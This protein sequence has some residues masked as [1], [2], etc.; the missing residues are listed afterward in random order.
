MYFNIFLYA[1]NVKVSIL[2][3]PQVTYA[4]MSCTTCTCWYTIQNL[5]RRNWCV[6]KSSS[7]VIANFL[8]WG[9]QTTSG[10]LTL[11]SIF[12]S[13]CAQWMYMKVHRVSA[14]CLVTLGSDTTKT[15][16]KGPRPPPPARNRD[17]KQEKRPEKAG[18]WVAKKSSTPH[19]RSPA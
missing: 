2:T 13:K 12:L 1:F 4:I 18:V 7:V 19:F 6:E 15:C 8:S 3:W 11:P 9:N 10:D 16:G 14:F 5:K 17:K